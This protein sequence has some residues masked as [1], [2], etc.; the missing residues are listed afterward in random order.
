[1]LLERAVFKMYIMDSCPYCDKA[2]DI[3]LNEER[4]S[5]HTINI[6]SDPNLREMIIEDTGQKTLPAIFIGSEFVGGHDDLCALREAGELEVMILKEENRILK[7]EVKRL[8]RS[9]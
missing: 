7:E 9:V 6:S 3:I 1:M 5:L 4:A 2:R 8:R